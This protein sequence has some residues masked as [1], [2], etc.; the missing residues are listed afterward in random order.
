MKY[1]SKNP[2]SHPLN[3]C[4]WVWANKNNLAESVMPLMMTAPIKNNRVSI[5]AND[6]ALMIMAVS[7]PS[8]VA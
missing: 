1:M 8:E 3:S 4:K 6:D 2:S 5:N 7:T